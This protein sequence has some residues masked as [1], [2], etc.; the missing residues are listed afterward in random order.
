MKVTSLLKIASFIL[1]LNN[2]F[3][4]ITAC[5]TGLC[6]LDRVE[7]TDADYEDDNDGDFN[8]EMESNDE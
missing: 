7:L 1:L 8:D 5:P 3:S 2:L 4:S 6:T